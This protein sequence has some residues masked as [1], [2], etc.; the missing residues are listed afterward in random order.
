M[1]DDNNPLAGTVADLYRH[2]VPG[3]R[4]LCVGLLVPEAAYSRLGAGLLRQ[5]V[6]LPYVCRI[7]QVVQ[8]RGGHG[9]AGV[10]PLFALFCAVDEARHSAANLL[11]A[12]QTQDIPEGIESVLLNGSTD[13]G[14]RLRALGLDVLLAIGCAGDDRSLASL[15]GVGIWHVDFGIGAID[16][17]RLAGAEEFFGSAPD[18]RLRLMQLGAE[19]AADRQLFELMLRAERSYSLVQSRQR[20]LFEACQLMV[21]ALHGLHSQVQPRSATPAQP[22]PPLA[23]ALAPQANSDKP[24]HLP[25][26][27]WLARPVVRRATRL[28]NA[29]RATVPIWKIALRRL[30][31]GA[32][33]DAVLSDRKGFRFLE[34]P[35]GYAWADP[36]LVDYQ[37]RTLLF[38]EELKIDT[39]ASG[40]IVCLEIDERGAVANRLLC[41][42]RPYHLSF[43]QVFAHGGEYFMM[44]ESMMD[45][46]VQLLRARRFPDDWV[47]EKVLFRG[48]AV[49]TV[50]WLDEDS[51]KWFFVTSMG[52]LIGQYPYTMVF[53][54]D[55]LTAPWQ[56]HPCSPISTTV[57]TERNGGALFRHGTALIRPVQD[58]RIRY[59]HSLQWQQINALSP[60]AYSERPI[61]R[62]EPEWAPGM[63]A[64]HSYTRSRDWEALD[65]LIEGDFAAETG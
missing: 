53:V 50:H 21:L 13:S 35:R 5:L 16:D 61:G 45:G 47:Q 59:G 28:L 49:D 60:S 7:T 22:V 37:G 58:G 12:A 31:S 63:L 11:A 36:H 9:H 20:L 57:Q 18:S 42:D 65:A 34:A 48:P 56:L 25:I 43:P 23:R 40:K 1:T 6:Q 3:G 38:A 8:R 39:A 15:C 27:S 4:E 55:S 33:V 29:R 62:V 32:P 24:V 14:E 46:T 54:A 51:G 44:P 26:L 2:S 10:P 30:Q 52:A 19:P 41:V 64:T 17:W